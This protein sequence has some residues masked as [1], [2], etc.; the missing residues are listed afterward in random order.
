MPLR[1]LA[2]EAIEFT[3]YTT[4][5]DVWA[6]GVL[7]WEIMT[8]ASWPYP[9]VA[10]L[11]LYKAL[12]VDGTRLPRPAHCPAGLYELLLSCWELDPQRR[13]QFREIHRNL[14]V[15]PRRLLL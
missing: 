8:L 15:G 14:Q 2:P 6:F 9:N 12:V 11:G 10:P 13:P 3:R 4:E 7:V 5:T 1:W